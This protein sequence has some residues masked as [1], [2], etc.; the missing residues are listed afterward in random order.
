MKKRLIAFQIDDDLRE[1][2]IKE[3]KKMGLTLSAYIR[4]LLINR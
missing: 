2:L 4:Y 3:G 1:S